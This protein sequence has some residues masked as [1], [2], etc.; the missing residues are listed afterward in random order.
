MQ[1]KKKAWVQVVAWSVSELANQETPVCLGRKMQENKKNN[2]CI[3]K[4]RK[5][6]HF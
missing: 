3:E 4:I 1:V 6:R 5:H 2:T